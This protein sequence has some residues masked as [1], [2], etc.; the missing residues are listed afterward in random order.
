MWYIVTKEDLDMLEA[1]LDKIED[2]IDAEYCKKALE[3]FKME[4]TVPFEEVKKKLGLT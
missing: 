4:D 2:K 1:F 3:N